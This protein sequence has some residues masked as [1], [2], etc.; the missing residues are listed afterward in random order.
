MCFLI[1]VLVFAILLLV[2]GHVTLPPALFP[3]LGR[4]NM[5]HIRQS[6]PDYGLAFQ[7]TVSFVPTLLGGGVA[8]QGV[9]EHVTDRIIYLKCF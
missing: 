6:R 2:R 1:S 3:V 9:G 4:A 8:G 5:A 7:V